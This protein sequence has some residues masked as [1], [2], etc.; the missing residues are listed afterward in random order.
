M[1][2]ADE[3]SVTKGEVIVVTGSLTETPLENSV[4]ATEVVTREEIV[5]SGAGNL[6]ELLEDQPGLQ[7]MPGF[8]GSSVRMLGFDA[9][10]IL[11]LVDGEPAIGRIGGAIELER[12]AADDIERIEIVKGA[13]ST[14][15]GSDAI[16]GVINIITRKTTKPIEVELA[17]QYGSFGSFETRGSVGVRKNGLSTRGSVGYRRRDAYDLDDTDQTT[18]SSAFRD[19]RA[20]LEVGY[21][22]GEASEVGTDF[23]F[24]QH[25]TDGEDIGFTGQTLDRR[26]DTRTFSGRLFGRTRLGDHRISSALRFSHFRDLFRY[27]DGMS[28][29]VDSRQETRETEIDGDL[30][31]DVLLGSHFVTTGVNVIGEF[32]ETERL[33]RDGKRA[34]TALFAQDEWLM[35]ERVQWTVNPGLRVDLDSQ[36]GQNFSPK[37]ATRLAPAPWFAFR[38][39]YGWGFRAPDFR[40]LYLFHD[41]VQAGYLLEG[42]PELKPETSQSATIGVE[43]KPG[44]RV[45][46]SAGVF[47]N[48]IEDL[49]SIEFEELPDGRF[50]TR[51]ENIAE[52]R[53]EGAEVQ[54]RVQP[55]SFATVEGSYTFTDTLDRDTMR[56]L[57]GRARHSGTFGFTTFSEPTGTR[58]R[59]HGRWTGTPYTGAFDPMNPDPYEPKRSLH[60]PTFDARLS[61]RAWI[62]EAFVGV[63]NLFD[64]GDPRFLPTQP[65][66]F[67][68]G[69]LARY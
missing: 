67:F 2:A 23:E 27:D 8:R 44:D 59:I 50:Y 35:A 56:P 47:W 46:L 58:L 12:F 24:T 22:S 16:G 11:I 51:Y 28:E 45:W 20:G 52:A 13:G 30:K 3:P 19:V 53:T 37:L 68:A 48:E 43:I 63:K 18:T 32:L 29:V 65:R 5:D 6:A 49:I 61:Q 33:S 36:F 66:T 57:F 10:H 64:A 40:E 25:E 69:L 62:F 26:T 55:V 21:Q 7:V 15:H 54:L 31:Y 14:L 38:A 9:R 42:N 39:S 41:N 1:A 17:E 4:V 34:R 60:Y